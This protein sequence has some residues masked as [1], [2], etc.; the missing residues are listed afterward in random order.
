MANPRQQGLK[1]TL[2]A[3]MAATRIET[4]AFKGLNGESKTTRI[5]TG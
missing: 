5:E 3:L 2:H 4:E 1:L